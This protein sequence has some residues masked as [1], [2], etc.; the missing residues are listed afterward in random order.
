[1]IGIADADHEESAGGGSNLLISKLSCSLVGVTGTVKISRNSL[2]HEAY[3]RTECLEE[4]RCNY[5]LNERFRELMFNRDLKA[6][7]T[8][9][10]GEI[11]M[12]ELSG[13]PFFVGTL[14]VPQLSSRPGAPHPLIVAF[15]VA[16]KSF[17]ELAD[18]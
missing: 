16:A 12:A 14:F 2:A 9:E 7:G 8:D 18:I 15:L 17:A 11:R 3:G 1:V 4:F 6:T 13:H 5:G 10:E